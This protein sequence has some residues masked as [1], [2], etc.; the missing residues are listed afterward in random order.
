MLSLIRGNVVD[1]P[2]NYSLS[3]YWCGG[4]MI[5]SF[6]VIQIISGIILSLLYVADSLLSFG[7]VLNMTSDGLFIWF[8]RYMHI[9]GVTFIFILFFVHMGRSL[10]YSSYSKLGV[11]NVGF[12]L[13]LL[14]MVEAFLGYILPWHQMSYWAATV[15]TSI[16]QSV[17]YVGS[18]LYKF[19]VGGFSVT[20]VTLVRVFSAHVC[21]A[22]IIVGL[23]VIHLFYLHKNGSNNPLFISGGYS[24]IVLFHSYF[25]TKDGFVLIML[26]FITGGL[27][28]W[29]PDFVLDVESYIEADPLV[30][31]VSIK[32]E[33]YFLA[34]YAM[35]RSVESKVGGL[36][37]VLLFLLVLWLPTLN[38]SCSYSVLRQ[39]VYWLC[40]SE[41]VL[42]SYLGACHPEAPYVIISKVS[43]FSLV[44]LVG[45][46]KVFWAVPYSGGVFYGL[47]RD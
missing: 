38:K 23:S 20:N 39:L 30:T 33:W 9:W 22:F 2:T 16:L 7:C 3:Y 32:P 45:L 11:W 46:Y 34:F 5:S 28:L 40:V 25:T 42:L 14:M 41:F 26:L 1:L 15:L 4:F 6:L 44:L 36:I 27:M 43:S 13:Y 47:R 37:L 10:Y 35:L 31:P 17:P 29:F 21:L 24:D 8:V 18:G 19:V 12:V